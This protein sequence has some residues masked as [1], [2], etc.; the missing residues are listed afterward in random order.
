M[1]AERIE[2]GLVDREHAVADAIALGPAIG[3]GN[4]AD[5]DL[6]LGFGKQRRRLIRLGKIQLHAL[7]L[8]EMR[9]QHEEHD[10]QKRDIDQRC[11]VR[12][13]ISVLAAAGGH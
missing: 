11:Q 12:L 5:R 6:V 2:A 9:H 13:D 4:H 3:R 8:V 1:R 10:Q 7:H